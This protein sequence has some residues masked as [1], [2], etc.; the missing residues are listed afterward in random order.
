MNRRD[1]AI[2]AALV[3]V[4]VVLGGAIALPQARPGSLESDLDSAPEASL[5]PPV[6]YRE[7][8]VGSPESITPVTARSRADRTL[9]GLIFSGLARPSPSGGFEPDLA[10]SWTAN[11]DGTSWTVAIRPDATW[12][13]GAPVTADDVVYTVE[14]LRSPD[15]AGGGAP[16]WADVTATALG[17]KTVRFTLTTPL[18][19]FLAALCQPLL[20]AHLLA[21]VPFADLADSE[22]ARMPVGT[23]PFALVELDGTRAV[24]EPAARVL[25]PIEP[26][27]GP[28]LDSL[29]TP[30][31][32]PAPGRPVPYLERIEMSFYETDEALATALQTGEIDG[33]AGY[34]PAA[35]GGSAAAEGSER[36]RYPTTT[37]SAVMLNLRPSHPELR[38]AKVRRALLAAV[39]RD[40]LVAG[41][42]AG[43]AVRADALIPPASW[44]FDATV[45]PPVEFDPKKASKA[46]TGAGW[47]KKSG[48]KWVAPRTKGAYALEVL[49][50]PASANPRLA[51]VAAFLRDAWTKLGFEVKLVE[52]PAADLATRL[53]SGDYVAAVVDVASGLEPDLYPLLAT[54]QVRASGRNLSGYQDPALDKLLE[55]ARAPGTPEGRAA[56]WKALLAAVDERMPILPIAWA[57]EVFLARGLQG[58]TPRLIVDPGDRF[59][60]VLAWRL[61]ADR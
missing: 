51:S 60:D 56:A 5:P 52:V 43:D 1:T 4:L 12:Q 34:P 59:G 40:A 18:G 46:L 2:I 44:A 13:D 16:S 17:P 24:L 36:L 29:A 22:F 27:P 3:L 21:D 23:G 37:L 15:A 54:S 50:V 32:T 25:P 10:E 14:A 47:T 33:A 49:T 53:Q 39:D 11:A 41:A 28:T 8:V 61:A 35:A 31:P 55:A 38:D 26:T 6:T 20:P 45:A 30:Y 7:G 58:P 42:L 48:G 57:D 19:G 9:A